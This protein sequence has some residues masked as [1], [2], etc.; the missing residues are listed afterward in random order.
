MKT[1]LVTGGAGFIG[2][3]FVLGLMAQGGFRI[4]NLDKLTYAGNIDTLAALRT[5]PDHVF[6]RGDIGDRELV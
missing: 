5:N 4:V 1:I 3:N 6:V 2:G